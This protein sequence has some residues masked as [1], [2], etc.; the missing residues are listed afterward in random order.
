MLRHIFFLICI[1]FG[2]MSQAQIGI[3]ISALQ[4]NTS[5]WET[6]LGPIAGESDQM[7]DTEFRFGVDYWFRLKNYRVEFLPTLQYAQYQSNNRLISTEVLQDPSFDAIRTATINDISLTLFANLY[8][9]DLEGDCNCPTFGKDGSLFEKGFFLQ[10]GVGASYL[11][12]NLTDSGGNDSQEAEDITMHLHIGA[13]VDFGV[14]S[15]VTLTPFIRYNYYL[16]TTWEVG[17]LTEQGQEAVDSNISQFELG[18]RLGLR[19]DEQNY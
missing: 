5:D 7:W 8:P 13:G 9:F 11:D 1:G 14:T 15:L 4:T 18:I 3:N 10:A 19:F 12:R 16:P 2:T 6:A 17:T